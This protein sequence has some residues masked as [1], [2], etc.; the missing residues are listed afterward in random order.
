MLVYICAHIFYYFSIYWSDTSLPM[1]VL[2]VRLV[3]GS[4]PTTTLVSLLANGLDV[5]SVL[6]GQ[7]SFA[8]FNHICI[9]YE[10]MDGFKN[11]KV[12]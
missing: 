2:H 8:I 4:L 11:L 6:H 9:S 5:R 10:A 7:V 1:D 3:C 12:H